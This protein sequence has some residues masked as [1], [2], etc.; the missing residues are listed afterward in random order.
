MFATKKVQ[1]FVPALFIFSFLLNEEG[2]DDCCGSCYH[3]TLNPI[4][5]MKHELC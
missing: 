1:Q 4:L 2:V 3:S 5:V